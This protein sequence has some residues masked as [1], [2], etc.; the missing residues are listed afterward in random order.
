MTSS[1][2]TFSVQSCEVCRKLDEETNLSTCKRKSG[3]S[4]QIGADP[5]KL[6][7]N[8]SVMRWVTEQATKPPS[9]V[10]ANLEFPEVR[11]DDPGERNT[12]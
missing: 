3:V 8:L 1:T 6:L 2:G 5:L 10:P 7:T 12:I 4:T 9:N 11:C